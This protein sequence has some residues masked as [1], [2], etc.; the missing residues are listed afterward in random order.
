LRMATVVC[1]L[2]A[3]AVPGLVNADAS[4]AWQSVSHAKPDT[5]PSIAKPT[6]QPSGYLRFAVGALAVGITCAGLM[7]RS[8]LPET[9]KPS[10]RVGWAVVTATGIVSIIA[11]IA[12]PF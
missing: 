10:R 11:V 5:L 12:R 7:E 4:S 8:D 2:L 6:V 9:A 1:V 3:L